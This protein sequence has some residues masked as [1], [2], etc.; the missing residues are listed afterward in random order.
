MSRN[1]DIAARPIQH[2]RSLWRGALL[3]PWVVPVGLAL[4]LGIAGL[5]G[6][7]FG[8]DDH[9]PAP[10]IGSAIG[11][12]LGIVLFGVPFTYLVTFALVVPMALLLRKWQALSAARLCL[13]C[14]I[15][16]PATMYAYAWFLKGQP[17]KILTPPGL[18]MAA[19]YGLISGATFC[20]ASQVR[21]FARRALPH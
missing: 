14:A 11:L 18:A 12:L 21:L 4:L 19:S 1:D 3:S 2:K 8:A 20:W 16:G 15:V 7:L 5:I 13:W 10:S 9:A 17:E 6:M